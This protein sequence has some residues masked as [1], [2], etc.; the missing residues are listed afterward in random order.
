[1]NGAGI[2]IITNTEST[3]VYIG[4]TVNLK[5]RWAI[6]KSRLHHGN[7][8]NPHLQAAWDFYG[9]DTFEFGVLEYLDDP[10]ELHLAEQFWCDIYREENR[11]L[12]N[13]ATIGPAPMLGRAV[14]EETRRKTSKALM[15]HPVSEKTRR[16]MSKALRG[17]P[18]SEETRRKISRANKGH[19]HTK[20]A[21]HRISRALQGREK[22][23]RTKEHGR[24]L[25]EAH[26]KPYPAFIHQDTGEII[27]AGVNLR[28]M[29]RGRELDAPC[30][31][32]VKVGE[33][34]H[35]KGWIL[36]IE[37]ELPYTKEMF[38]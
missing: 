1:M 31:R 3:K 26:G 17:H 21:K 18:V 10:E 8:V 20:E 37:Q 22:P 14:S 29:C 11:E 25:G 2:Y 12:Y 27:P 24:N 13:I 9:G 34:G 28:A 30:M 35:H 32:R 4:S 36:L 19:R 15:G 33:R 5:Q 16:K 7:H 23:P 38:Q 6:H